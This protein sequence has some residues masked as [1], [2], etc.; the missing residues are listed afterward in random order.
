MS[1]RSTCGHRVGG[2]VGG[3]GFTL[4]ELLVV[5]AIIA[6]LAAILFPVFAKARDKARQTVCIS[7]LKQIAN[8]L[9]MYAD[10]YD[11]TL[12]SVGCLDKNPACYRTPST[13]KTNLVWFLSI[14]AYTKNEKIENCPSARIPGCCSPE[15]QGS[16]GEIHG[17]HG[18]WARSLGLVGYTGWP[19]TYGLN[20]YVDSLGP[21]GFPAG[22]HK[23]SY[24][25]DPASKIM[26]A[27]CRGPL[28]LCQSIRWPETCCGPCYVLGAGGGFV[29]TADLTHDQTL[30]E[31]EKLTRHSGGSNCGYFDG[32]VKWVRWQNIK[33]MNIAPTVE[34]N[35][36]GAQGQGGPWE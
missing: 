21:G 26:T 32:H 30:A 18:E 28:F 20:I 2:N 31:L 13:Y 36:Q 25:K 7:N 9:L 29:Y 16:T 33:A 5:I 34:D 3:C 23:L 17:Q 14:M 8:A 12:P 19:V 35:I 11:E 22:S 6:I 10:D 24:W 4:I 15:I 27:D 1:K